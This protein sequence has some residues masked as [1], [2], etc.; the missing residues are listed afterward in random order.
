MIDAEKLVVRLARPEDDVAVGEVLVE[1]YVTA[2]AQKMPHVVVGE[3]RRRDLRAVA[4][5]RQI[6]TVLVADL[7]GAVI[8][9]VAIFKPGAETSEAW[10]PNAAD[11]RHLAMHPSVQGRGFARPLLDEAERIC[12]DEWR[13]SAICLHVRRGNKGVARLYQSRGY[14]RDPSGDLS[15][16]EVELE[17]YA[18]RF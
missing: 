15:Y 14:V 18:L 4:Q 1:G 8:G 3:Q 2:Y 12:R 13:V 5:K 7:N 10:L 11:L 16:P 9:T 17:A 6:A